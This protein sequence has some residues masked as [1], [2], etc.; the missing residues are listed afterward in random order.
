MGVFNVPI[1]VRNWQN[2]LLPPSERGEEIRCEAGVDTG[3][4]YLSLPADMVERLKL[5][6]IRNVTVRTA[7]GARHEFRIMAMAEVEVQG[8][9]AEVHVLELPRGARPL[10]GAYPLEIVDWHVA[11]NEQ[12]LVPSPDSPDKPGAWLL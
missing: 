2:H 5:I 12:K 3:A 11:P 8:R 6:P 10:L 7:D 9:K 1:I 4:A